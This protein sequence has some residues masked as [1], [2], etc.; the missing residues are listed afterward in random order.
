MPKDNLNTNVAMQLDQHLFNRTVDA[1]ESF[2]NYNYCVIAMWMIGLFWTF[3]VN[4][5]YAFVSTAYVLK[6]LPH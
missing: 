6:Y 1:E 3:T 2:V 5:L 4:S